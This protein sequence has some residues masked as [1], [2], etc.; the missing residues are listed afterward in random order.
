MRQCPLQDCSTPLFKQ[1]FFQLRAVCTIIA[2]PRPVAV[3]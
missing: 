1:L 2:G 3:F